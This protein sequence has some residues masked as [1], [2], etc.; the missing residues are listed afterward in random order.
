MEKEGDGGAIAVKLFDRVDEAVTNLLVPERLG[1]KTIEE[2]VERTERPAKEFPVFERFLRGAQERVRL[3]RG[4]EQAG[5]DYAVSPATRALAGWA[6]FQDTVNQGLWRLFAEFTP[7]YTIRNFLNNLMTVLTDRTLSWVR[8]QKIDAFFDIIGKPVAAERG[9]G[10]AGALLGRTTS[11]GF[12]GMWKPF[13]IPVGAQAVEQAF[14]R[15]VTY[16]V[17]KDYL[18]RILEVGKGI[19]YLPADVEAVLG[20]DVARG[21]LAEFRRT[22][23]DTEAALKWLK[24]QSGQAEIWR[25]P[26]EGEL[27][28]LRAARAVPKDLDESVLEILRTSKTPDE[29]RQRLAALRQKMGKVAEQ[30]AQ[31]VPPVLPPGSPEYSFM[32]AEMSNPLPGHP[33]KTFH[34]FLST[35]HK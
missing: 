18:D 11:R 14:S 15:N 20:E 24:K 6:G 32:L 4:A 16:T 30:T 10:L 26:P 29:L 5:I 8:G 9:I 2:F 12:A 25:I 31:S 7:A 21:M 33:P 34:Q 22:Y 19:P 35:K 13:G 3:G 27:E 23:G 28:A 17:A 1:A